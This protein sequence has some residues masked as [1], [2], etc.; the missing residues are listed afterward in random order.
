[1]MD[2][3]QLRKVL[4]GTWHSE[5]TYA[6][7]DWVVDSYLRPDWT[8]VSIGHMKKEG[9]E[10]A[11]F[12]KGAWTVNEGK[13]VAIITESSVKEYAGVEIINP[14]L[15]ASAN[16][17][18]LANS[19]GIKITMT[20]EPDTIPTDDQYRAALTGYWLSNAVV[21]GDPWVFLTQLSADGSYVAGGYRKA[22]PILDGGTW[23]IQNG[24]LLYDMIDV[25]RPADK[26]LKVTNEIVYVEADYAILKDSIGA[27]NSMNRAK[28]PSDS[29]ARNLIVGKWRGPDRNGD[30][31][32]QTFTT[33]GEW[34]SARG[35]GSTPSGAAD[36]GKGTWRIVDG[37]L[38]LATDGSG[39]TNTQAQQ[40]LHLD[41]N[42][43][44]VVNEKNEL[45]TSVPVSG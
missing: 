34:S 1:M 10:F 17:L 39:S 6:G 19:Q 2:D 33:E 9:K 24:N 21:V 18:T 37:V 15:D 31:I 26:G 28:A 20:R 13:F 38:L 23:K 43:L 27:F 42:M 14:I 12:D 35:K 11:Y 5:A 36:A 41:K 16:A 7:A 40:L 29:D 30:T 3:A 44:G 25:T 4:V 8:E 22:G 45:S 32:F